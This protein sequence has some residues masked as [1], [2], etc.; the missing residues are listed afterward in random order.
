MT[1]AQRPSVIRPRANQ[2]SADPREHGLQ[3]GR[4]II[5]VHVEQVRVV[6]L[7]G[8][9]RSQP[10]GTRAIPVVGKQVIPYRLA[11]LERDFHAEFGGSI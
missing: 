2:P 8:E 11:R 7:P 6:V 9:I 5:C 4:A 10:D 1:A 3:H